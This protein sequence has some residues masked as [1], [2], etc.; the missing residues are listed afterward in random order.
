MKLFNTSTYKNKTIHA[1]SPYPSARSTLRAP[2]LLSNVE[3]QE[4]LLKFSASCVANNP[5]LAHSSSSFVSHTTLRA[6]ILDYET[7]WPLLRGIFPSNLIFGPLKQSRG[8]QSLFST[9]P[10]ARSLVSLRSSRRENVAPSPALSVLETRR[11]A[12]SFPRPHPRLASSSSSSFRS[13]AV[14]MNGGPF[15]PAGLRPNSILFFHA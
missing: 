6:S 5:A 2:Q 14:A 15:S 13:M 8:S 12:V 3:S 9:Q 11:I 4:K 7:S 1:L 10:E